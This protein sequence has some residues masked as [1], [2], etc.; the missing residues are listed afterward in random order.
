MK[1]KH[2]LPDQQGSQIAFPFCT[3]RFGLVAPG[4]ISTVG[5]AVSDAARVLVPS[6]HVPERFDFLAQ[7][8]SQKLLQQCLAPVY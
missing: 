8:E 4:Q 2:N 6:T 7:Q 3:N 1:V 5:S